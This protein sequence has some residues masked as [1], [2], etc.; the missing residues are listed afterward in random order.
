[1]TRD[2][3]ASA[4]AKLNAEHPHRDEFRW[5]AREGDD[6]EWSVARVR[7]PKRAGNGRLTAEER[8]KRETPPDEHPLDLPGGVSPGAAGF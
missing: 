2:E 6:G 3:A 5:G 4:A 1:M 7:L 8:G